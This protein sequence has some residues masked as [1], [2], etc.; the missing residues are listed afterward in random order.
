MWDPQAVIHAVEGDEFYKLSERGWVT[1]TPRGETLFK[2]DPN[3]NA[4]YQYP[5]DANWCETVLK[6][7]RLMAIQH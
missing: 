6:Y 4:R 2:P 1:L 5:G 7:I 3:G